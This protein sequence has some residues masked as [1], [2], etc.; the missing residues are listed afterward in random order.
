MFKCVWELGIYNNII[1]ECGWSVSKACVVS[2]NL[3][4]EATF[5]SSRDRTQGPTIVEEGAQ[6]NAQSGVGA[7]LDVLLTC[8]VIQY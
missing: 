6:G 1:V 3:R 5:F 2:S 8:T 4:E 7:C